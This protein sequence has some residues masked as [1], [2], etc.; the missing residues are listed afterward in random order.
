MAIMKNVS[1]ENKI[2][3]S[4][5]ALKQTKV[6]N[7]FISLTLDT[8]R[9][10][11]GKPMPAA[12]R[13]TIDRDRYYLRLPDKFTREQ[14]EEICKATGK[15]RVAA[16]QADKERPY[17]IKMRLLADFEDYLQQLV[18]LSKTTKLTIP[19]IKTMITGKSSTDS[20]LNI[21]ETVANQKSIGTCA[22]YLAA[23]NSFLKYLG[24]RPGFNISTEDL[25]E[26]ER[27]LLKDGISKTT[28]G[29]YFRTF[30]VIWNVC[31]K[32]GFVTRATYPF[33]KGDDKVTI[34]RGAT[35]KS[36]YL[37]VEQ[38]TE[39]Y[40]CFLEK[41]YP[42][43]W[44]VDWKENTH[45]SLGLFLVQYLGNGFNLADAAH[46][47]YNDHYFQS[48]KKSFQFVRQKT[49]DRS[50]NEVVIPI[51]PP[52]QTI[53]DQIAAPPIKGSL[54][55][56]GIYGDA[57]APIDRRK[58]VA[59][60]NQN[61]KKR[62][63]RLVKSMGWEVQPSCTWCRHSFATNLT[64]AGV[65]HNYI[66]ESMG[67]SVDTNITNR[68]IDAFPLAQQ[69]EFNSRLLKLNN[70]ADIMEELKGLT[71]EQLKVLIAL[72]KNA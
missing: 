28:V 10:C 25:K 48:G 53:L 38:M 42:E 23:R 20:F 47:T 17:D 40:N 35:R 3:C 27:L 61:I 32:K 29:M 22:N 45:Y 34:S 1:E 18:T 57:M 49:E 31:E 37:T 66:S 62:V 46:L 51:I 67:H 55:F 36:F 21:W 63:R 7:C 68:Y 54:V 56:P 39:L 64:H 65:P 52:L 6:G 24:N 11:D 13:F 9:E 12:I 19:A 72:A 15:G 44:D 60:E 71:P 33:G 41:R 50:D 43:E 8:R 59:M 4:P 30:R 14:Y 2:R 5:L 58:R 70:D 26:W 16:S 69:M